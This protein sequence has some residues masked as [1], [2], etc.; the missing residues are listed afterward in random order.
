MNKNIITT[1]INIIVKYAKKNGTIKM[2]I[3]H[4]TE[5]MPYCHDSKKSYIKIHRNAK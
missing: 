3:G 5:F 2:S 1:N 4:R